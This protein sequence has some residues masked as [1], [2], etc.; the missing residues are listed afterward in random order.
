[1][2]F[3]PLNK[4]DFFKWNSFALTHSRGEMAHLAEWS[5]FFE[6]T[7]NYRSYFTF[8]EKDGEI[9]GIL[10]LIQQKGIFKNILITTASGP[11]FNESI[12][13]DEQV[14]EFLKELCA[15][16]GAKDVICIHSDLKS[17]SVFKSDEHVRIMLRLPE[18]KSELWKSIGPK[19]RNTVRK[20]EKF[21]LSHRIVVPEQ[22][23][24]DVFYR[25]Y[26]E[27]YRDLGTP[28][29]PKRY[30]SNQIR[31]F[32][33][34]I[35][36]LLVEYNGKTIGGMW[37]NHFCNQMSDPEAASMRKFFYTG[38]ND[39]MYYRSFEYG[40]DSG[41]RV[42]NMG[43]SLRGSGTYNFK[44]KWGD[45][46]IADYPVVRLNKNH[47]LAGSKKKYRFIIQLWKNMPVALTC[48]LGPH[49]RKHM[50]FE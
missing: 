48:F 28:V 23:D 20:A 6:E 3:I 43:R 42:F 35:K 9:V 22:K 25:I 26:S 24:I 45:I 27:N 46:I 29:N 34:N 44:K 38:V 5:E 36:L 33:E 37:L 16:T 47:T 4:G 15:K 31:Y 40:I 13:S 41:C 10:P 1:M 32:P 39:F 49:I 50:F 14:L 21:Q 7:F 12:I 11:L 18:D 19:Q 8:V 2:D 17:N 30:F